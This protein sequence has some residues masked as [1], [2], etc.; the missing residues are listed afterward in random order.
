[1]SKKCRNLQISIFNVCKVKMYVTQFFHMNMLDLN[2][3]LELQ[4]VN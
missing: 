2:K 1:M 3:N 4:K